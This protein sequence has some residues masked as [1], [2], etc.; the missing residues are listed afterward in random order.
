MCDDTT[1][2]NFRTL[3]GRLTRREFAQPLTGAHSGIV[4]WPDARGIRPTYRQ[5]AERLAEFGYAVLIVNPYFRGH[6]A[7]VLPNGTDLASAQPRAGRTRLAADV[8]SVFCRPRVKSIPALTA[9]AD[10]HQDHNVVARNWIR[11]IR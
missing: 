2:E 11:G 9:G 3:T 5:I 4:V 7:P 8:E 6:R 1:F 10:R